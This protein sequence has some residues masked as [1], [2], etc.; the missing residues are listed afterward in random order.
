MK[1]GSKLPDEINNNNDAFSFGVMSSRK[2]GGRFCQMRIMRVNFIF[3]CQ[4]VFGS[5]HVTQ[6]FW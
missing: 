3:E 2:K 6:S 5:V 4:T 1:S